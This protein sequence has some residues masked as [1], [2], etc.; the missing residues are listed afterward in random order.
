MVTAKVADK[1][2]AEVRFKSVGKIY[3]F[4]ASEHSGLDVGDH[5]IVKTRRGIQM[6]EVA[7]ISQFQSSER[8]HKIKKDFATG[9]PKGF[10]FE[11]DLGGQGSGCIRCLQAHCH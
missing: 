5:V 11:A 1:I 4:D 6:A 2:V 9:D 3:H 8:W 10:S 7:K